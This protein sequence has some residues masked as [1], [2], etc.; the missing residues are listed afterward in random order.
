[1]QDGGVNVELDLPKGT[2][3]ELIL[4]LHLRLDRPLLRCDHVGAKTAIS[5]STSVQR[6]P[7]AKG[8]G[9]PI[10]LPPK[11]SK[12][13]NENIAELDEG[14]DSPTAAHLHC[15][16]PDS[17]ALRNQLPLHDLSF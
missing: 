5:I 12:T 1:V 7:A 4:N 6:P 10:S 11:N 3:P 13:D 15:G 17:N 9:A 14:Y 8:F 2:D 16:L